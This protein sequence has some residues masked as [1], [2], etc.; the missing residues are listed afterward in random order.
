MVTP[1]PTAP[2][3]SYLD[4][5]GWYNNGYAAAGLPDGTPV[6]KTD[7][8]PLFNVAL[9]LD[10][11][12][13]PTAPGGL[14]TENWAAR[15]KDIQS[16]VNSDMLWTKYGAVKGDYNALRDSLSHDG[17]KILGENGTDGYTSS[18]ESRTIWVQVTGKNFNSLFGD[19]AT[20]M[21][22]G[23]GRDATYFWQG[24][25]TLPEHVKGLW[26]D[27]YIPQLDFAASSAAPVA[28]TT[29]YQGTGNGRPSPTIFTPQKVASFYNFP[30]AEQAGTP[31]S[32]LG[33]LE[34]GLGASPPSSTPQQSIGQLLSAYRTSVG[35]DPYVTVV[36]LQPGGPSI[37]VNETS[38]ERSLDIGI[39]TAVNPL[40]SL[41]L[42]AGSGTD[43]VNRHEPYTAYFQ[44]IWDTTYNP[45]VVSSSFHFN[46][47]EPSPQSPF[48]FA[49]RELFVDAALRNISMFSSSGDG[50]SSYE[51]ANGLT[52]ASNSRASPY[53]VVVGGTSLTTVE[54]ATPNPTDPTKTD[55]TL[56]SLYNA[57]TGSNPAQKSAVLWEL[58]AG[59]LSKMPVSPHQTW[60]AE[61]VW[62]RYNVTALPSS[63]APGELSPG[64]QQNQSSNSGVD[65]TQVAPWYQSALNPF[66]P[67][68]NPNTPNLQGRAVPDVVAL[69]AGDMLYKVP[70][71][72]M[73]DTKGNGGTSAATPFWASLAVQIN[74]I[75]VDQ[76]FPAGTQLGYMNDLLYIAAAIAPGAY[77]DVS[78]GSNVSTFLPGTS[79]NDTYQTPVS[80]G[81]SSLVN[82]VP[83][84]MGYYAGPG[85]D[86]ATGLGSPN[87]VLLARAIA[88]IAHSQMYF[89]KASDV[90]EAHGAGWASTIQQD[91]LVQVMST[92]DTTIVVTENGD[93]T[94]LHSSATVGHAWTARLAEQVLQADFDSSLVTMFD[95]A[96]Q[97]VLT[98]TVLNAGESLAVS[99]DGTDA[100]AYSAPLTNSF[101][102]NDF[103][104]TVGAVRFVRPVALAETAL[105]QS[106][107]TAIVRIRQN[108][109]DKVETALYKV[110]DNSG[111]VGSLHP[112]D[113]GYAAAALGRTYAT[114]TGDKA[115]AGPGYGQFVQVELPSVNANDIIAFK[116]TNLSTG[117]TF[118]GF[119]QANETVNGEK[120]AHLWN[121]GLNTFGFEDRFGGG[122]RDYN[123]LIIGVDFT[124]K[125]G[126]DLLV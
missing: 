48:M 49:A 54:M 23:S 30:L 2:Y 109:Q 41:I 67:A 35:L 16:L 93:T 94:T 66:P 31:T 59:G 110:D 85:Y 73:S 40:S 61:A 25:L 71:E 63:H 99:I 43:G 39:A 82:I 100:Q 121:Y 89:A 1:Q 107:Q 22:A 11:A 80:D 86:V 15:Q 51:I 97:G 57:A 4:Y 101:G 6:S 77:N 62:N 116:L 111:A 104:T 106:D 108:G 53:A 52:N 60:F 88:D 68:S 27:E 34:P 113:A 58:V 56:T 91:L 10:R 84:G 114:S 8:T 65:Y 125:S 83:T 29:G 46:A 26:F 103:Q 123:D 118:W 87:G 75:L 3:T 122:D 70:N 12:H 120:V 50:G 18:Q 17:Y 55:A 20:L 32:A 117:N 78:L 7:G 102:F 33:L 36:G 47:A 74:A 96:R 38:S 24:N 44:S 69:S 79:S 45:G 14:L 124:S 72:D 76:G 126:S 92:K 98:H 64:Y 5:I 28:L 90:L 95:G 19:Q 37:A 115:I 21:Q 81:D 119:T 13:D 42:Y 9:V 105:A 112:G